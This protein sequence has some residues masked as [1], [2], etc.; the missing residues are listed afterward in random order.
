MSTAST[1]PPSSHLVTVQ[2]DG[3]PPPKGYANGVLAQG[4]RLYI[5]GQVGWN[6]RE[7]IVGPD[8]AAQFAQALDNVIAVVRH[9]G[10]RATDVVRMTVFVTDVDA[11]VAARRALR[12]I[13]RERFGEHYP[14]MSLIGIARLFEPGALVE[15]EAVAELPV[16]A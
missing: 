2:P 14:A 10:G 12:G 1:P 13:W 7:E 8:F 3:W 9:A 11:Y 5:A 6:T 4:R 16:D 15:I